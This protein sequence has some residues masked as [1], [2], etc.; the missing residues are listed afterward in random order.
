M[1]KHVYLLVAVGRES[2]STLFTGKWLHAEM[3]DSSMPVQLGFCAKPFT[4]LA[5]EQSD[6]DL[7][8]IGGRTLAIRGPIV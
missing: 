4:T 6:R 2:F 8:S 5:T 3:Y 1:H 7:S